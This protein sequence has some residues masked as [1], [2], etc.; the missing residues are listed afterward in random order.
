MPLSGYTSTL[1]TDVLLDTG[2]LYLGAAIFGATRGGLTF[3]P[4]IT[5]RNVEFDGKVSAVAGL[6]RKVT[7]APTLSGTVIELG[8]ADI[9]RVEPGSTVVASGAW[10]GSTSYRGKAGQTLYASGDYITDVRAVWERGAGGFVQVRFPVAI[11]SSYNVAGAAGEEAAIAL[12]IEARLDLTVSGS[13]PSDMP[14]R[15][16]FLATGP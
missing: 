11:I 14:Y 4:G 16:E 10:T 7:V 15:I 6:D 8:A 5:W 12:T 9:A 13:S 1:P 2:T 3:E